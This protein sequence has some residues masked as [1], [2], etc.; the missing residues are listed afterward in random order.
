MKGAKEEKNTRWTSD[1][2]DKRYITHLSL[3]KRTQSLIYV[4]AAWLYALHV[5]PCKYIPWL[6]FH[7]TFSSTYSGAKCSNLG[8][9]AAA[10]QLVNVFYETQV[11][12]FFSRIILRSHGCK[13]WQ[14]DQVAES[15]S[16][17]ELWVKCNFKINVFVPSLPLKTRKL[18]AGDLRSRCKNWRES[19]VFSSQSQ[20]VL[21]PR[22]AGLCCGAKVAA[23]AWPCDPRNF[24]PV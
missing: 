9:T 7:R 17:G 13:C 14:A 22:E 8:F 11:V 15:K 21:R 6:V 2:L 10:M 3:Q 19:D 16:P 5:V 4:L 1:I 23:M 18:T 24:R 20:P 12:T